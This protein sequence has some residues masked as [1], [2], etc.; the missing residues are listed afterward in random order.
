[1]QQIELIK[2]ILTSS[3]IAGLVSAIVSYFTTLKLKK[4]DFKTEYYKEILKKRLSAYQ[5]IENQIAVLKGDAMDSDGKAYHMI[6]NEGETKFIEYQQNLFIAIAYSLWID[7]ETVKQL[8]KLNHLFFNLNNH[9]HGKS[10]EEMELIGK[11]YYQRISDL[12]FNLENSVKKG[13]YNLHDVK[14]AFKTKKKNEKRKIY[15]E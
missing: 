12:R 10:R 13:L 15:K 4:Y 3:V 9:V 5:H 2:I 8:E 1:M 7:D 6:F 14:R 11:K